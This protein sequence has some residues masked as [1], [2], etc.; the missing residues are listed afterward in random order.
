M[1]RCIDETLGFY[2][3]PQTHWLKIR[4]NNPLERVM[5][6][7]R[8]RTRVVGAFPDG[9]SAVMLVGAWLRHIARHQA[10]NPQAHVDELVVAAEYRNSAV[11]L[12]ATAEK[13]AKEYLHYHGKFYL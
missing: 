3:Y 11:S 9:Q 2:S 13:S 6:E 7:I 10:G 1:E 12:R 8:R 4:T 5:R